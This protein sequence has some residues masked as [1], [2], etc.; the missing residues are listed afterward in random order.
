MFRTIKM[1]P[2]LAKVES[3]SLKAYAKGLEKEMADKYPQAS[4]VAG[5]VFETVHKLA[6]EWM[7]PQGIAPGSERYYLSAMELT[8]RV[9]FAISHD[10]GLTRTNLTDLFNG[11]YEEVPVGIIEEKQEAI[12][13]LE[14]MA[15]F[16][17]MFLERLAFHDEKEESPFFG[18][19]G[20]LWWKLF[21]EPLLPFT[22]ANMGLLRHGVECNCPL[23]DEFVPFLQ[24]LPALLKHGVINKN[25]AKRVAMTMLK[26]GI[27]ET[28]AKGVEDYKDV[29]YFGE[30]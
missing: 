13:Y 28:L 21:D 26:D 14:S 2:A 30:K 17:Y 15:Y 19:V 4:A 12:P 3:N 1:T 8:T 27:D 22:V 24:L 23:N 20:G 16:Q 9:C 29:T 18:V 10:L 7:Y 6:A 11:N 25:F 5:P